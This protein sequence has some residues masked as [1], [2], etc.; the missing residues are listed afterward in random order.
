MIE[1]SVRLFAAAAIAVLIGA[2]P[3][4]AQARAKADIA[5]KPTEK[6]LQ[7]DCTIRL[8]DA[9]T[10]EPLS[11][12]DIMVGADMPSMP[13]AHNVRPVRATAGQAPGTYAAKIELEMHGEWMLRLDLSGRLRDRVLKT[14]NFQSNE[15]RDGPRGRSAPRPGH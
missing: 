1:C 6:S 15:V 13:M 8:L 12:V 9:R 14:L 7:F 3:A 11:G 4:A 5:C 10:G 2:S